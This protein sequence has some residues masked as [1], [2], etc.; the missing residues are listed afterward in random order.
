MRKFQAERKRLSSEVHLRSA[1]EKVFPLLC[2]MREYDWI[3]GWIC[4][5][6]ASESGF[7]EENCIFKCDLPIWGKETWYILNFE[8]GR[9]WTAI[10]TGEHI[11]TR[12][13]LS[14]NEENGSTIFRAEFLLTATDPEGNVQIGNFP[15]EFAYQFCSRLG[16]M[17]DYY[18]ENGKAMP[19]E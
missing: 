11:S 12:I 6:V 3:D 2:P 7:A 13:D 16:R 4:E 19:L 10:R 1:A 17:L 15:D 18:I 9:G 8:T 5:L 14:L